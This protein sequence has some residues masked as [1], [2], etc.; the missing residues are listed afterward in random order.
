MINFLRIPS[1]SINF[2][3]LI[4][5]SRSSEKLR[6]WGGSERPVRVEGYCLV[7]CCDLY[8]EGTGWTLLLG[9]ILFLL[10]IIVFHDLRTTTLWESVLLCLWHYY[11][12]KVWLLEVLSPCSSSGMNGGWRCSAKHAW[13]ILFFWRDWV[14]PHKYRSLLWLIPPWLQI[15]W[16]KWSLLD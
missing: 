13:G 1:L 12:L 3:L 6:L 10:I 4:F 11:R 2:D 16:S 15:L 8:S 9:V 14:V 7:S 5:M